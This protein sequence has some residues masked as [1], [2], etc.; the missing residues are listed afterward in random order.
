MGENVQAAADLIKWYRTEIKG[1]TWGI[2]ENWRFLASYDYGYE[3][4]KTLGK[5]LSFNGRQLGS[6]LP[7][8][9]FYRKLPSFLLAFWVL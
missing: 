2:A 3:Q 1:A 8:G 6:M 7:T 9:K 5:V 4:I